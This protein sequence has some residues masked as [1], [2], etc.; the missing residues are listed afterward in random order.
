[1]KKLILFIPAFCLLFLIST[2]CNSGTSGDENSGDT[3]ISTLEKKMDKLE[4]ESTDSTAALGKEYTAKYICP[5]HCK[6]SGSD[7]P[8]TCS[9][10]G[11]ELIENTSVSK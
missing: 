2:S 1:M 7:K 10:C 6:G 4:G 5:D 9:N 11:M 3:T 8:G